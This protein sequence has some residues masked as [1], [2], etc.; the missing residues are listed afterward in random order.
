ML[1]HGPPDALSSLP[2]DVEGAPFLPQ[3]RLVEAMRGTPLRT[4][5]AGAAH[6]LAV[7][8]GGLTFAWGLQ[9]LARL[10][11]GAAAITT[12]AAGGDA[13][14]LPAAVTSLEM[15]RVADVAAGAAH[16]CR[17]TAPRRG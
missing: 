14:W 8:S 1:G 10:G 9:K 16:S 2:A 13:V 7:S 17:R 3:P 4:V 15:Q 5:S 11:L 12:G 6:S